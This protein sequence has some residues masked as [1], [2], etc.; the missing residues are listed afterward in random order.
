VAQLALRTLFAGLV[1][2]ATSIDLLSNRPI[3][4]V[5][6]VVMR[7]LGMLLGL[8]LSLSGAAFA[9]G[10]G[11][12]QMTAEQRA[13]MATAHEQM[14]ACL[15]T[16]RPVAECHDE[17]MKSCQEAM[18]TSCPMMGGMRHHKMQPPQ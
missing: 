12:P 15:R 13:K 1:S 7:K 2:N 18:G 8:A 16:E 3:D 11:P 17:L 5:R 6:R 9:Q 14:A 4:L 10:K